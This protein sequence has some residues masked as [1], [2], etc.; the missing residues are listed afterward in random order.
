MGEDEIDGD[1]G[2]EWPPDEEDVGPL[3]PVA[4]DDVCPE[5]TPEEMQW[6]DASSL[7]QFNKGLG[8]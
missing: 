8:S 4:L 6:V 2:G 1:I 5:R 7:L 3:V